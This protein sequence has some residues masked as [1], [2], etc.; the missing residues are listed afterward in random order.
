MPK[1]TVGGQAVLEGLMI[2]SPETIAVA[3]RRTD[4]SIGLFKRSL[5]YRESCPV[6]ADIPFVRGITAVFSAL[7]IGYQALDYSFQIAKND[8]TDAYKKLDTTHSNNFK[9]ESLLNTIAVLTIVMVGTAIFIVLPYFILHLIHPEY[10]A[11]FFLPQVLESGIRM[12]ML[13][14]YIFLLSCIPEV[15]RVFQYHGAEHKVVHAHE[16]GLKLSVHNV[17]MCSKYHSRC[18]TMFLVFAALV[19]VI[20]FSLI[21]ANMPL[22]HQVMIRILLLPIITGLSFEVFRHIDRI[23]LW[24]LQP[25]LAPGRLFQLLT[26]R[27]PTDE[28]LETAIYAIRASLDPGV[29]LADYSGKDNPYA[30]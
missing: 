23:P 24:I 16:K 11:A 26:T 15:E 7:K 17:R 28:Q 13:A 27:E 1:V 25:I 29:T 30:G 19:T 14:A 22:N 21:P 2:R 18:G 6:A 5:T 9:P 20:I 10:N 12:V 8:M 4:G 3:V